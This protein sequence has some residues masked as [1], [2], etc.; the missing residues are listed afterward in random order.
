MK[1][2]LIIILN[3]HTNEEIYFLKIMMLERWIERK[4]NERWYIRK[5]NKN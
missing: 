5:I 2:Q 4:I 3:L 1:K